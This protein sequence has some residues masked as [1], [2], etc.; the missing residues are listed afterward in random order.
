MENRLFLLQA[1][2]GGGTK[3][4]LNKQS[5][6]ILH[7]AEIIKP[8]GIEEGDIIGLPEH[9][10]SVE[11]E[12]K[13]EV[14]AR[15]A[16]D[17]A[18]QVNLKAAIDALEAADAAEAAERAASDKVHD[19]AIAAEEAARID[20]DNTLTANLNAE[21]ARAT[22][23]DAEHDA[24]IAA[25]S[26][27]RTAADSAHDVE[28][29]AIKETEA[30]NVATLQGNIDAEQL[31]A[32]AAEKVN[33]DAIAEEKA[34]RI[35][36]VSTEE[37]ARIAGDAALQA[38]LNAMDAAYKSADAGLQSAIDSAQAEINGILSG[39]TLD[40]NS[41]AEIVTLI[42]SV[43]TENDTAF[44]SYVLS[45]DAAL[46]QEV[47]DR[48]A[49]D[50]KLTGDLAAEVV[51]A[52]TAEAA[53]AAAI[54]TEEAARVAADIA[55]QAEL[56]KAVAELEDVNKAQ[57]EKADKF[58]AET[59]AAISAEEARAIAAEG[60][61]DT[62][63]EAEK[64]RATSKD[65]EHDAA[66]AAE[67]AARVAADELH[68]KAIASEKAR[69]D[70]I[71]ESAA[72]TADTFVEVVNLINSVDTENDE[73]FGA[74]VIKNDAAIQ[75]LNEYVDTTNK[76]QD[77]K[78]RD[79]EVGTSEVISRLQDDLEAET[80]RAIAAEGE[81]TVKVADIIE[82]TDVSKIDSFV[83]V[84]NEFNKIS[85]AN[86]DSIYAKKV[87][88]TFDGDGEATL[89]NPV[90]PESL[91][92]YI[93]GLMVELGDDYTEQ[94][95]DGAVSTVQFTGDALELVAAGAKLG[96]YGVH[97][98]FSSVEFNGIDYA[99]LIDA[100]QAELVGLEAQKAEAT[101]KEYQ[102]ISEFEAHKAKLHAEI[103]AANEVGDADGAAKAQAELA[104]IE[105][106]RAEEASVFNELENSINSQ[107]QS[108]NAEIATL[109]AE[110][111]EA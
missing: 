96:A 90:K 87:G 8:S 39:S 102:A 46:A 60:V 66:L 35:S 37:A 5:D 2:A 106:A 47:A 14:A 13:Q 20:G 53:N 30:A 19:D 40:A 49:G 105:A 85:E 42:N 76:D 26:E 103:E 97:G 22:A 100:K 73:V 7:E 12:I 10:E 108:L 1:P 52:T 56:S 16:G 50:D 55:I 31:R 38:S 83:E 43:D 45:N 77:E 91:Q 79:F 78:F 54:A 80:E 17:E 27:A 64:A 36:A 81:L 21:V 65:A 99:A 4:V 9:F 63:I 33:A 109:H 51:R 41:F 58:E 67:E 88:I 93:N 86:F 70:A 75:D 104:N 95:V 24:A 48:I 44:A 72:L 71:L 69:I 74:Y 101:D 61:L 6:L 34:D 94:V 32:E 98:S 68:D 110:A 23:K 28:I 62:K 3:I 15:E 11:I 57:D 25:E 29:A 82:N 107:I 84:I 89:A 111:A 59:N 18:L 92:V